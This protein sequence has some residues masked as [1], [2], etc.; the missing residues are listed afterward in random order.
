METDRKDATGRGGR[1][2]RIV[3][4]VVLSLFS[5]AW[6]ALTFAVDAR[7]RAARRW[8]EVSCTILG[9]ETAWES[10]GTAPHRHSFPILRVRFLLVGTAWV[11]RRGDR[12]LDVSEDEVVKRPVHLPVRPEDLLRGSFELT[13]PASDPPP[14]TDEPT[15]TLRVRASV[16]GG[17]PVSDD[18]PLR[19]IAARERRPEQGGYNRAGIPGEAD[20]HLRRFG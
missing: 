13:I 17:L 19:P 11:A 5:L 16:R 6:L 15:W 2:E 8:P 20:C 10:T 3:F 18:Y 12:K 9:T 1:I 7:E 14:G 4:G